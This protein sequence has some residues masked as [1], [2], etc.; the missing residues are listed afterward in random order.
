MSSFTFT[1]QPRRQLSAT[2]LREKWGVSV[3]RMEPPPV[4]TWHLHWTHVPPPPQADGKNTPLL[5][6]VVSSVEPPS[7]SSVCSPLMVILSLP[8]GESLAFTNRSRLTSIKMTVRK[9]AMVRISVV[10]MSDQISM[11]MK[12]MNAMPMSPVM[13]NVMP[14]PRSGAGTCE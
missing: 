13:M 1:W 14:K 4:F 11:P 12:L 8:A 6:K 5:P 3:G 9:K 7:T 2:S 10:V